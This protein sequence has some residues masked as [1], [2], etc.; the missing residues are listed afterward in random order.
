MEKSSPKIKDM[1]NKTERERK[2]RRRRMGC[3]SHAKS[4]WSL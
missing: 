2:K 1:R 4:T 3:D